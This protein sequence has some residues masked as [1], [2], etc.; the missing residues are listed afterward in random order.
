MN[1]AAPC[2]GIQHTGIHSFRHEISVDS[3][4]WN[5]LCKATDDNIIL[6]SPVSGWVPLL[7]VSTII[8][9]SK[10]IRRRP[11]SV[12]TLL[13][14]R[15]HS[16]TRR[17]H[18][19]RNKTKPGTSEQ[20]NERTGSKNARINA[21]QKHLARHLACAGPTSKHIYETHKHAHSHKNG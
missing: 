18:S 10:R 21:G 16:L 4:I 20:T 8:F 6:L 12:K 15:T 11:V 7:D 13:R 1:T 3:I 2:T 9:S 14:V 19:T 5:L 17:R